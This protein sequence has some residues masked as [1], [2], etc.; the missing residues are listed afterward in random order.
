VVEVQVA[1]VEAV[2]GEA[3]YSV[4]WPLVGSYQGVW[5]SSLVSETWADVVGGVGSVHGAKERS[6]ERW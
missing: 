2:P 6:S 1:V 3:L 5:H 4:C